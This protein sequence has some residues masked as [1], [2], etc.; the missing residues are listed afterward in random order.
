MSVH[1]TVVL[2]NGKQSS[3]NGTAP[4]N[5]P[6][7]PE[8]LAY[9]VREAQSTGLKLALT[10]FGMGLH[11]Y[12]GHDDEARPSRA[13][14]KSQSKPRQQEPEEDE[15]E[16]APP[17]KRSTKSNSRGSSNGKGDW[18][19]LRD[20]FTY[21]NG[22]NKGTAYSNLEDGFL[23]WANENLDPDHEKY[24]EMNAKI[25]KCVNDEIKYRKANGEWNPE[26]KKKSGSSKPTKKR[27]ISDD[28]DESDDF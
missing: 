17:P 23:N 18:S 20:K 2:P 19:T 10:N 1:V 12:F 14:Q 15:D 16:D 27:S 22:K 13:T 26:T 7:S 11:L 24:G 21:P 8:S 9:A 4:L 6:V 25:L 5:E 28:T 3:A